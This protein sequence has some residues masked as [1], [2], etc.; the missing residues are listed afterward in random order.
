VARRVVGWLQ[1]GMAEMEPVGTK[2]SWLF[3]LVMSLTATL[4]SSS[5]ARFLV[6][7]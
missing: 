3:V 4:I 6:D 1:Q 2:W 5:Q 7:A